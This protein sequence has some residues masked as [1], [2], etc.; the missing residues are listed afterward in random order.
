MMCSLV[1]VN[2]VDAEAAGVS[3]ELDRCRGE[4][5]ALREEQRTVVRRLKELN[6][7]MPQLQMTIDSASKSIAEL[8]A[9]L[10][11]LIPKCEV[12]AVILTSETP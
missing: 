12:R 5:N 6:K 10:P 8:A 7:S 4:L 11:G 1:Q 3:S 9:R 2:E